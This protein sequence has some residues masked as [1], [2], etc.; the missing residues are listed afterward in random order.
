MSPDNISQPLGSKIDGIKLLLSRFFIRIYRR[1][2]TQSFP[3]PLPSINHVFFPPHLTVTHTH[4]LARSLSLCL[5]FSPEHTQVSHLHKNVHTH[6]LLAMAVTRWMTSSTSAAKKT[7]E[8]LATHICTTMCARGCRS[9][10]GV[11][12]VHFLLRN[13]KCQSLSAAV[14]G[15]AAIPSLPPIALIIGK[16]HLIFWEHI[17]WL[18]SEKGERRRR[19]WCDSEW[20]PRTCQ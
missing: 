18:I 1:C 15:N 19:R 5:V 16:C 2:C 13:G 6:G 12:H 10:D 8:H 14:P 20:C 7:P 4:T 9:S 17:A 11:T 3:A